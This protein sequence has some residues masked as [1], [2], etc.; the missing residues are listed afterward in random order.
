[1]PEFQQKY[2]TGRRKNMIVSDFAEKMGMKI[3]TGDA[4][5]EKDITG[6]YACDLLSWVMSHASTGDAWVTVQSHVNTIAVALLSG[7]SCI[8]LPEGINAEEPTLCKAKQEG[9]AILSTEMT[10][11]EV[12]YRSREILSKV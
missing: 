12:C 1:M 5:I 3:L 2:E 9:I 10:T 8:I 6:I 7:I 11:Y 4:G